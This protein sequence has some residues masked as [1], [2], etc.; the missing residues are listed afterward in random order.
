MPSAYEKPSYVR[1]RGEKLPPTPGVKLSG[2]RSAEEVI[3]AS[4][5]AP[6]VS[7]WRR[8]GV[9]GSFVVIVT[10]VAVAWIGMEIVTAAIT[11]ETVMHQ[12]LAGTI[13]I[14]GGVWAHVLLSAYRAR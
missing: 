13:L 7:E 10:M 11:A 2:Q 4:Q 12:V 1:E 5:H 3:A 6:S 14:T 8:V 9:L